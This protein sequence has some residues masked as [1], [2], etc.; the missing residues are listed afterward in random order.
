MINNK[1]INLNGTG[2]GEKGDLKETPSIKEAL[3]ALECEEPLIDQIEKTL[4]NKASI[5][6]ARNFFKRINPFKGKDQQPETQGQ[7]N[8]RH[9]LYNLLKKEKEDTTQ[10]KEDTQ[11]IL[12]GVTKQI[13]NLSSAIYPHNASKR[14]EMT[15]L[16]QE[17]AKHDKNNLSALPKKLEENIKEVTEG[18]NKKSDVKKAVSRR[19]MAA[20]F[21]GGI[22]V[23][24]IFTAG[25]ILPAIAT[26]VA[27]A[28]A[29]KSAVNHQK[30]YNQK[31]GKDELGKDKLVKD[32][33]AKAKKIQKEKKK[34]QEK[35]VE[36]KLRERCKKPQLCQQS[37]G[38]DKGFFQ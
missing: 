15:A 29:T 27:A 12:D 3:S 22:A 13:D 38:R 19:V 16:L 36:K 35:K 2:N 25:L 6:G 33:K 20:A 30:E 8:L 14:A 17:I 28:W 11:E 4:N 1:E 21:F 18:A 9:A 24:S 23:L 31:K 32:I 37:L 26:G 34:E 5:G 10:T 7:R